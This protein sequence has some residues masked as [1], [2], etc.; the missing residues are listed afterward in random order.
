MVS[1]S[2]RQSVVRLRQDRRHGLRGPARSGELRVDSPP[3]RHR[4][5]DVRFFTE[6]YEGRSGRN[7][8][9]YLPGDVP[10]RRSRP[11]SH[12]I[13]R[14]VA[15][16]KGRPLRDGSGRDRSERGAFVH[17]VGV[18]RRL[19]RGEHVR[20]FLVRTSAA[21]CWGRAVWH[22]WSRRTPPQRRSLLW[23]SGDACRPG[24]TIV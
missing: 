5:Q 2:D 7:R 10:L 11:V 20:R 17:W 8:S 22:C 21:S 4:A 3:G 19:V 15:F 18:G 12:Q 23:A 13:V 14:R 1:K 24:T 9:Q 16:P 6:E